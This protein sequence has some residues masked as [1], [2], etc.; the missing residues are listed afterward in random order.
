MAELAAPA[1]PTPGVVRRGFNGSPILVLSAR[2]TGTVDTINRMVCDETGNV[3]LVDSIAMVL[4]RNSPTPAA[5]AQAEPITNQVLDKSMTRIGHLLVMHALMSIAVRVAGVGKVAIRSCDFDATGKVDKSPLAAHARQAAADIIAF[6]AGNDADRAEDRKALFAHTEHVTT[7]FFMVAT[8]QKLTGHTW[9]SADT[10]RVNTDTARIMRMAGSEHQEMR[11]FMGEYG[12]D[13]WH[14]LDT[15]WHT[16]AALRLADPAAVVRAVPAGSAEVVWSGVAATGQ[17][18]ADLLPV[19]PAVATRLKDGY[20]VSGSGTLVNMV[21]AILIMLRHAGGTVKMTG[22][23]SILKALQLMADKAPKLKTS[24]DVNAIRTILIST[25]AL[26][27][28]YCSV[29]SRDFYD[30]TPAVN[31]MQTKQQNQHAAGVTLAKQIRERGTSPEALRTSIA[32]AF[33]ALA[34]SL[35]SAAAEFDRHLEADQ[36]GEVED[37]GDVELPETAEEKAARTEADKNLLQMEE[38]RAKLA[39]MGPGASTPAQ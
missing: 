11:Q 23:A 7:A 20:S 17:K 32:S 37:L 25:S 9:Y 19:N 38:I 21:N 16:E 10:N 39:A 35:R 13:L 36:I 28:G 33:A 15:A 18:V 4:I 3:D 12:H 22:S 24:A 14:W 2:D 34:D 6:A 5:G 1:P 26:A 30:I 8:H 27:A 31:S 29:V